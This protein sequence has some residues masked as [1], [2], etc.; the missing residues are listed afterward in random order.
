MDV[1]MKA[2]TVQDAVLEVYQ[3]H[4]PGVIHVVVAG[5]MD[6]AA[7]TRLRRE[8]ETL[9][10]LL[11][12]IIVLDLRRSWAV[13]ADTLRMVSGGVAR[14]AESGQRVVVVR[15]PGEL[16]DLPPE[17]DTVEAPLGS[18]SARDDHPAVPAQPSGGYLGEAL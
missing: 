2:N 5:E 1:G 12:R 4:R 13:G 15:E 18:E 10:S 11:V 8:L 16:S 9:R 3:E 6:E 14:A 7:V 17:I